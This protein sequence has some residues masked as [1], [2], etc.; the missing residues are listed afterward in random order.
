MSMIYIE[1]PDSFSYLEKYDEME[2]F[3]K[4]YNEV[5][6]DLNKVKSMLSK[7]AN[8]RAYLLP[9]VYGDVDV[10]KTRTLFDDY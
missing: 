4:E 3:Y 10:L 5:K 2:L 6:G 8:P 7:V 1:P 9:E